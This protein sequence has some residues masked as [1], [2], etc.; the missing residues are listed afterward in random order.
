M[1]DEQKQHVLIP[2]FADPNWERAQRWR[3]ERRHK[4]SREVWTFNP[5]PR[6]WREEVSAQ[7]AV[8]DRH[9]EL[10]PMWL[11]RK[12]G[13][14]SYV[15]WLEHVALEVQTTEVWTQEGGVDMYGAHKFPLAGLAGLPRGGEYHA[16]TV[17]MLVAFALSLVGERRVGK[18][19][20]DGLNYDEW[21]EPYS[22]R[23]CLEYWLGVAE[24]R[25]VSV[26]MRGQRVLRN[27]ARFGPDPGDIDER[28]PVY[29]YEVCHAEEYRTGAFVRNRCPLWRPEH[30]DHLYAR[31]VRDT[32]DYARDL[33][34]D[35]YPDGR[36]D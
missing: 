2:G 23:A 25:G 24:G 35:L 21:G 9:F 8:V 1:S 27:T 17:D 33:V 12:K 4:A 11:H 36:V 18:L 31:A 10:H 30:P 32:K 14:R 28:N 34:N 29:G 19:T 6:R 15:S 7:S 3:T 26:E 22:A 16:G 5:L 13:R 20:L